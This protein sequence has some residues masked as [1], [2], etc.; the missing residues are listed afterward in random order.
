MN[1]DSSKKNK[2][3]ATTG[4]ILGI[5]SFGL[6][7][8]AGLSSIWIKLAHFGEYQAVF[9]F[10]YLVLLT[11][12]VSLILGTSGCMISIIALIGIRKEGIHSKTLPTVII[13]LFLGGLGPTFVLIYLAFV[14]YFGPSTPPHPPLV[15]PGF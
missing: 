15:T 12:L 8:L 9:S 10:V 1:I 2:R 5:L 13:S 3:L 4:L 14:L 11:S 6:L 7:I